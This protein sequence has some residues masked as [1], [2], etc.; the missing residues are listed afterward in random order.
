MPLTCAFPSWGICSEAACPPRF[1]RV[2]GSRLGGW[3]ARQLMADMEAGRPAASVVG[4][5][6]SGVV[7]TPLDE[8]M[9]QIDWDTGRRREET[10]MQ[11]RGLADTLAKPG[12]RVKP[13]TR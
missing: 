10:F 12:P 1:D 2:Q 5:L 6:K 8:A 3:A 9:K 4:I 13:G 11:W 7:V